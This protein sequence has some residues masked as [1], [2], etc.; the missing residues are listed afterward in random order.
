MA[1]KRYSKKEAPYVYTKYGE[2]V[3]KEFNCGVRKAGSIARFG[4]SPLKE[5]SLADTWLLLGYI[6]KR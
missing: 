6:K 5:G 4:L 3:A 1:K 2:K